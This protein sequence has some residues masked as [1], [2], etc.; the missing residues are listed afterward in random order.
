MQQHQD[1]TAYVFLRVD[2]SYKSDEPVIV[3]YFP[4]APMAESL[5]ALVRMHVLA[6]VYVISLYKP[7]PV[8]K[9]P[10][11]IPGWFS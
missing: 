6:D 2:N 1:N 4:Y 5:D 11:F 7:F 3:R 9:Y 8:V 10:V